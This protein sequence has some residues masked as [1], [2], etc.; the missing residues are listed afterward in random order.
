MPQTE[1]ILIAS[2]CY[3]KYAKERKLLYVNSDSFLPKL[4]S[5]SLNLFIAIGRKLKITSKSNIV[6]GQL[7]ANILSPFIGEIIYKRIS[8]HGAKGEF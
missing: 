4:F 1:F 3:Q 2:S 6:R 8:F 5:K 7:I